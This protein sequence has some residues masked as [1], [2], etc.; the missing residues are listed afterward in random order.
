MSYV[1]N[2]FNSLPYRS[3]ASRRTRAFFPAKGCP[4]AFCQSQ[5]EALHTSVEVKLSMVRDSFSLPL[6]RNFSALIITVELGSKRGAKI[7]FHI[8]IF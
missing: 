3:L 7:T 1:L 4:R 6:H 8:L 5:L 2:E